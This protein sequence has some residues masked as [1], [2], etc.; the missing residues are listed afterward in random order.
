MIAQTDYTEPP[1]IAGDHYPN[2][3]GTACHYCGLAA[4]IVAP[5]ELM[6][7]WS[8][9]V[10]TSTAEDE[11]D[12][13]ADIA[14]RQVPAWR[15]LYVRAYQRMHPGAI[16]AAGS[17]VPDAGSW[18]E[19]LYAIVP[20]T[21][22]NDNGRQREHADIAA[23]FARH[24]RLRDTAARIATHHAAGDTETAAYLADILAGHNLPEPEYRQR[25]LGRLRRDR[26]PLMA[27]SE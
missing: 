4:E 3:D 11:R 27:A 7:A 10:A 5:D 15:A 6:A 18:Y 2:D 12:R 25:A 26:W 17:M 13:A 22:W 8:E 21:G 23:T 9:L 20:M 14:R 24:W 1:C 19:A 16:P